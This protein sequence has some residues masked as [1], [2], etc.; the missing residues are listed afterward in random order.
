MGF[1]GDDSAITVAADPRPE[2]SSLV[3]QLRAAHFN[4]THSKEN[5]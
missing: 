3:V 5:S 1:T 4:S 2:A